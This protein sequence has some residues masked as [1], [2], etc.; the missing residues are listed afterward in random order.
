MARMQIVPLPTV[1][2]ADAER[3]PFLVVLDQVGDELAMTDADVE[4]MRYSIGAESI[5][6][7]QGVLDAADVH[8]TD[9]QRAALIDRLGLSE[10]LQGGGG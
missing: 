10:A 7:S 2:I 6:L 4:R 8:L 9:A 5:V 3:T 1:R